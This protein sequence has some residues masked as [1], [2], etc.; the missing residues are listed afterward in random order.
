[1]G[2]FREYAQ[3]IRMLWTSDN[4][5]FHGKYVHLDNVSLAIRP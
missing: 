4:V 1:V 3:V 2:R 5:T